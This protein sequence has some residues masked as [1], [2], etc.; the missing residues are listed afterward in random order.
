MKEVEIWRG[1]MITKLKLTRS[2]GATIES[3]S[4][5]E[6]DHFKYVVGDNQ[7]PFCFEFC[8]VQT[9]PDFEAL[10]GLALIAR[11]NE[12]KSLVPVN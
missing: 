4:T 10:V 1:K 6:A 8:T 5:L 3:G 9:A 11:N 12:D 2:D 7:R